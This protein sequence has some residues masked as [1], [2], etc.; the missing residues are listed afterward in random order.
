[1]YLDLHKESNDFQQKIMGCRKYYGM[2]NPPPKLWTDTQSENIT[3]RHPSDAGG[4][5]ER[6]FNSQFKNQSCSEWSQ[7]QFDKQTHKC[8]HTD[9]IVT[10]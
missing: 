6:I 8:N 3:S 9:T 1:M 10:R 5:Y 2:G 4:K 7:C